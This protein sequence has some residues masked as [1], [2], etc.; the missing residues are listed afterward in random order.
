MAV[1]CCRC[2]WRVVTLGG[3]HTLLLRYSNDHRGGEVGGLSS[4]A[5]HLRQHPLPEL[6]TLLSLATF[7]AAI[8][9][10]EWRLAE[11]EAHTYDEEVGLVFFGAGGREEWSRDRA[12]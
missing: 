1:R 3:I 11:T 4:G 2:L 10:R 6:Q 5:A 12:A 8:P 9:C 7:I